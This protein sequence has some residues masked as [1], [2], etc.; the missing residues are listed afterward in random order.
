MQNM[1][2]TLFSND[3]LLIKTIYN[4]C[5]ILG[6]VFTLPPSY[7]FILYISFILLEINK[8]KGSKKK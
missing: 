2:N 4:Q 8:I 7:G 1:I 6:G 5:K 3:I